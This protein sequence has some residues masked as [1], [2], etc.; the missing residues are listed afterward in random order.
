MR[1]LYLVA[2]DIA[3]PRRL[4][5]TLQAVKGSAAGGQRSVF[6]CFLGPGERTQLQDELRTILDAG[7]DSVML[8]KLERN[9]ERI[10]LGVAVEPVDPLFFY[11]G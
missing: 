5:R 9:A 4:R 11:Q 1:A 6:E 2:Y 8:L 7:E 10:M 3:D